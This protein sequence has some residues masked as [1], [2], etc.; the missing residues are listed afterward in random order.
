MPETVIYASILHKARKS[1]PTAELDSASGNN[2]IGGECVR[3]LRILLL[4]RSDIGIPAGSVAVA[5]LD[6]AAHEE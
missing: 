4:R 6:D 5:Q 1:T 2:A 3:D